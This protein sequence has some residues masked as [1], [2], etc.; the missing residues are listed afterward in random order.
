[1]LVDQSTDDAA[2][3]AL[4]E[5]GL[6]STR[7]LVYQR[8]DSVGISRARNEGIA[9]CRGQIIAFTDDDCI[10]PPDWLTAYAELFRRLPDAAIAFGPLIASPD[11][12]PG[13]T[14]EFHPLREGFVSLTPDIKRNLGLGAN[15][16]ARREAMEDI[17]PFDPIL[18]TGSVFGAGEDTDFAFRAL[19]R[20][21]GVYVSRQ[22]TVVHLGRREGDEVTRMRRAYTD[23]MVAMATKHVRCGDALM[24]HPVKEVLV[25]GLLEGTKRILRGKRPSGYRMCLW[26][27][28]AIVASLHFGIDKDLRLYRDG[29]PS[30]GG[31]DQKVAGFP[32]G[33]AMP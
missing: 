26:T 31:S 25:S 33:T 19:R 11:G 3:T 30:E 29:R 23:G 15:F 12:L 28:S 27:I 16:A 8:S 1:V 24:L 4:R 20:G 10:A 32:K 5:S 2:A 13:W 9:R 21:H 22:P 18:G 6:I 17:G 7:Q 14:P